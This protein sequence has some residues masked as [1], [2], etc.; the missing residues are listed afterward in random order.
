MYCV[1]QL[2]I[3]GGNP[4][5]IVVNAVIMASSNALL[6]LEKQQ[7]AQRKEAPPMTYGTLIINQMVLFVKYILK[8]L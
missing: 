6:E 1:G 2:A 3:G 5:C 7:S 4:D 8:I